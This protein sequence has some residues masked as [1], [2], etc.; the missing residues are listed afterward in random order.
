MW[1]LGQTSTGLSVR[2]ATAATSVHVRWTMVPEDGDTLWAYNGHSGIDM[3][4]QDEGG[5]GGWR[6]AT[7]SGNNPGTAAGSM[8]AAALMQA[9]PNKTF[10]AS[11]GAMAAGVQRNLTLYLPSRG[12]LLSAEVG[13][14]AQPLVELYGGCMEVLKV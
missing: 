7:S 3:Y 12:A 4:V 10:T 5:A 1:G 6:W 14:A 8:S 9:G 13:V 11:L 2:F